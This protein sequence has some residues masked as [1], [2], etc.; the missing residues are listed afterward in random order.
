MLKTGAVF[1][2]LSQRGELSTR[3]ET[4]TLFGEKLSQW[5]NSD[6]HTSAILHISTSEMFKPRTDEIFLPEQDK[7]LRNA[8]K[9]IQL[10]AKR[11]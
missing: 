6:D 5:W 10:Q 1:I 8:D 7:E 9:V 4:L 2:F 3:Q 11:G